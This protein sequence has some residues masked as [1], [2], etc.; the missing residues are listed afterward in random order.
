MQIFCKNNFYNK[1]N[2]NSYIYLNI[3]YKVFLKVYINIYIYIY[4][5]FNY[6]ALSL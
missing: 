4:I 1:S 6:I 2:K 5:M 3:L